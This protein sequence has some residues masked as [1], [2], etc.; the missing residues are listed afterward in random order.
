MKKWFI[1][2]LALI[3]ILPVGTV[4]AQL[5]VNDTESTNV[6]VTV[7]SVVMVDINPASFTWTG[8]EPGSVGGPNEET[9]GYFAI[10]IE[11][12]GS[13]N[14][15]HI[16]FNNSWSTG[17]E[18]ATGTNTNID[19]G[20]FVVLAREGG[21]YYFSGRR[22]WNES[23]SLVYLKDFAG[24]IPPASNY[25]YGRFHNASYEY[26]WMTDASTYCNTTGHTIR[27]GNTPHTE[28]QTG[29]T[30]FQTGSGQYTEITL[31]NAGGSDASWGYAAITSGPLSGYCIAVYYTCDQ[32][33][34]YK[35]NKDAPGGTSCTN[36]EY[37]WDA[38]SNPGFP[39]VPGNSTVANIRVFVPYGI[40]EGQLKKGF[41]TVF[42]N[43]AG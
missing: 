1:L 10:Q 12:I 4:R 18:F 43:D 27:I 33:I 34:F 14:I 30:N 26:F 3:A 19:S 20:N 23:R 7:S 40:Y 24:S 42:V 38:N 29:S 11:N 35:W 5:Q 9:N 15:T 8:V 16:W 6:T 2:L 13:R 22:E 32:V 17:R 28:S 36:A 39:L 21:N 25:Y 41:L 37:F 31:T